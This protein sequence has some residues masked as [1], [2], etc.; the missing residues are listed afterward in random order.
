[1]EVAESSKAVKKGS[2]KL[3]LLKQGQ[4]GTNRINQMQKGLFL[5]FQAEME[6]IFA[7]GN[8]KESSFHPKGFLITMKHMT[9]TSGI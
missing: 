6:Q 7:I 3:L 2:N 9:K 1:M 4:L 5:A 8:K